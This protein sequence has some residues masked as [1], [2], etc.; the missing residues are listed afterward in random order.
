MIAGQMALLTRERIEE[1]LA[2]LDT[3][4]GRA[5]QRASVHLMGGA[6]MCLVFRAREATR[7]V[8]AWFDEAAVVRAAAARV[9]EV[10]QLPS[11]WLND[12]AKAMPA[13]ARFEAWRSFPNLE[14][15][16]A[17]ART[18]FAMK[19]AAARTAEDAGDIRLLANELG[20][21]TSSDALAAVD[22]YY[23]AE[24]LPVRT[25]LLLEE[26]LDDRA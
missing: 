4:L 25:R 2:A 8:D 24:R 26:M 6:V 9:A 12:A 22:Q 3:E 15:F 11:D 7:D 10:L 16:T 17:H 20:I 13:G 5:G 14:I 19:C 21:T 18:M 23:P 1:A